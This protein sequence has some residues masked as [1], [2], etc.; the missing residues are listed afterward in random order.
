[1]A[2]ELSFSYSMGIYKPSIMSQPIGRSV[3]NAQY[4]MTGN[5]YTEGSI[6]VPTGGVAVPLGQVTQ[7][8]W[9]YLNNLDPTNFVT[10]AHSLAGLL[11]PMIYLNPGESA[12]VPINPASVPWAVANTA[13]VQMEFLIVSL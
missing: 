12:W 6:L 3:A 2:L 4:D 5:F 7:P 8:H 10:I 11:Y 9:C 1:M 13:S